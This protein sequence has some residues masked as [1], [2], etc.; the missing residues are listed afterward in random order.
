MLSG[1]GLSLP[2]ALASQDELVTDETVRDFILEKETLQN[3][4]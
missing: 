3:P 4:A 2:A 1:T